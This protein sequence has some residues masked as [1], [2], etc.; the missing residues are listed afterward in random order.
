MPQEPRKGKQVKTFTAYV[1]QLDLKKIKTVV[2]VRFDAKSG[3]FFIALP[4]HI[5]ATIQGHE[6]PRKWKARMNSIGELTSD[7]MQ[8]VM[9]EYESAL[10]LFIMIQR[11]LQRKKVIAFWCRWNKPRDGAFSGHEISFCGSPALFLDYEVMWQVGKSLYHVDDEDPHALLIHGAGRHQDGE[12]TVIDWTKDR[13]KF[14]A[15]M[16]NGITNLIDRLATFKKALGVNADN[17]IKQLMQPGQKALPAPA[18][19]EDAGPVR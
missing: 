16:K 15:D 7:K 12:A 9:D 17:A 13:E 14:F 6:N 1:P 18:E 5:T 2:S 19:R 8:D 10:S 4:E 3:E 11:D